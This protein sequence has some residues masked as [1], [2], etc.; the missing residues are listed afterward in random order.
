MNELMNENNFNWNSKVA[1]NSTCYSLEG[2]GIF[3]QS[4]SLM[5]LHSWKNTEPG[6]LILAA[7]YT[8]WRSLS[9]MHILG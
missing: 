5:P 6:L 2:S 4:P 1:L 9:N 3:S 8:G 7:Y